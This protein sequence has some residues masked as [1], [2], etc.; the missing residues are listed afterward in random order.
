MLMLPK[1][2][3]IAW[4]MG[5]GLSDKASMIMALIESIFFFIELDKDGGEEEQGEMTE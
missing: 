1:R 2:P 4:F 5:G 3:E